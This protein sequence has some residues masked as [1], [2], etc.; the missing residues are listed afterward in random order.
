[1]NQ[2]NRRSIEE[3][4]LFN[5]TFLTLLIFE[6]A[7]GHESENSRP[8]A[9]PL[10]FLAVGLGT[11]DQVQES[12]PPTIATSMFSWL[13]DEPLAQIQVVSR[14]REFAPRTREAIR[15]G[16]QAEALELVSQGGIRPGSLQPNASSRKLRRS[17]NLKGSFFAGRWFARAGDPGTILAAWGASV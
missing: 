10:A 3:R 5:P 9:F 4:S 8:L 6:A 17:Q 1:M 7:R 2:W 15:L 11:H 16:V 14:A 12:L 13:R